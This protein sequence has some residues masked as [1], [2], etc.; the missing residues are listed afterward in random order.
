MLPAG[1]KT[2]APH[3]DPPRKEDGARHFRRMRPGAAA[4]LTVAVEKR[5]CR[6]LSFQPQLLRKII[7]SLDSSSLF[8]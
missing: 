6:I 4:S 5:R 7:F 3:L 2:I 8:C 1:G